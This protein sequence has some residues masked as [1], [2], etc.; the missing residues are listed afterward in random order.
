M[1]TSQSYVLAFVGVLGATVLAGACSGSDVATTAPDAPATGGKGGKSGSSGKGGSSGT[2]AQAAGGTETGGTESGGSDDA[3]GKAG[4]TNAGGSGGATAGT[5]AGGT[6][7]G[8]TSAGGAG[9]NAGTTSAGGASAGTTSV[10]GAAGSSAGGSG[11]AGSSVTAGT[12]SGQSGSG[13]AGQEAD[14]GLDEDSACV[15][16]SAEATLVKKPVDIIL[17][18]DNSGSMGGEIKAVQSNINN[19]LAKIIGDSGLDYRVILLSRHG[20]ADNGQSVCISSP[21]SGTSCNPIPAQPVNT[22]RFKHYSVEV[23]SKNSYDVI[24]S[25]YVKKDEFGLAT[26]GWREWLRDDS[27]K[28]F[29]EI[30]DDEPPTSGTSTNTAAKFDAALLK[31][32]PAKFGTADKRNYI[33]HSIIG[34]K[35]HTPA[36]T[37][38]LPTEAVQTAT[39]GTGA[40]GPAAEYQKL[41]ILTGGLRF[42]IC[43]NNGFDV[44][45]QTIAKGVVEGSK[46]SCSFPIPT[47]PPGQIIEPSTIVV[48]YT[49]GAGGAGTSYKQVASLAACTPDSF[50]IE[51]NS[52]I[53]L[54]PAVCENVQADNK[55]KIGILYGCGKF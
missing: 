17:V 7:A 51:Q 26:T 5:S 6:S 18:I 34:L 9:S 48:N 42:P 28:V 19:N 49:P 8:T 33:F 13:Q 47:P 43:D 29:V 32:M 37:P 52:T 27:V 14:G 10:G 50:Y 2:S 1:K 44:V 54:C 53:T 36:G 55:A 12:S 38:W 41:S 11:Q 31:L 15:A 3:G 20:S 35:A 30:T 16:Q 21:L 25:T 4:T 45:F 24:L 39:C 23:G 46:I 22:E 40:V